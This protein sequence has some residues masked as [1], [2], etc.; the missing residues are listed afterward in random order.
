[1]PPFA[2]IAPP[3]LATILEVLG[4]VVYA[5][6]AV[7]LLLGI[8]HTCRERPGGPPPGESGNPK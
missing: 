6:I 4:F 1:M 7:L 5:L 8:R 2:N 3:E